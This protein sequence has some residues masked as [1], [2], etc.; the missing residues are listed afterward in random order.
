MHKINLQFTLE[1]L[2]TQRFMYIDIERNIIREF[3]RR[4]LFPDCKF[5]TV[6]VIQVPLKQQFPKRQQEELES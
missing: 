4:N 6:S 1:A 3:L 2:V 5:A